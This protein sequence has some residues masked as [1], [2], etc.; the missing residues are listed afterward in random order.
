MNLP[1]NDAEM[2]AVIK[3]QF[4]HLPQEEQG[5]ERFR[6]H[7]LMRAAQPGN[8]PWHISQNEYGFQGDY[9]DSDAGEPPKGA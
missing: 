2:E 7:N 4:G 3:E 1:L 9:Q 5:R 6:L 8:L